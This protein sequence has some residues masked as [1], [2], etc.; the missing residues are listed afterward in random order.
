MF[1]P[2]FFVAWLA[3]LIFALLDID[4]SPTD[5]VRTM[6]GPWWVVVVVLVPIGGSLAWIA[7]GRPHQAQVA[8]PA[9]GGSRLSPEPLGRLPDPVRGAVPESVHAILDRIDREF[10]EAVR[11]RKRRASGERPEP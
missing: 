3:L 5:R 11:R 2:V 8:Q 7:A 9:T 10:D 6:A 4:R 1:V